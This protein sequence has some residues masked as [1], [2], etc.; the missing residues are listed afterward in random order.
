MNDAPMTPYLSPIHA[1]EHSQSSKVL[2]HVQAV[3]GCVDGLRGF[4]A[5]LAFV[6]FPDRAASWVEDPLQ[7]TS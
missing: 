4:T 2:H 1:C 6:V 7:S 5:I 3:T